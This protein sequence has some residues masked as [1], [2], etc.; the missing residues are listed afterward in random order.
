MNPIHVKL[1]APNPSL[2]SSFACEHPPIEVAWAQDQLSWSQMSES[3]LVFA[4]GGEFILCRDKCHALP[5]AS[6]LNAIVASAE[7]QR[8]PQWLSRSRLVAMALALPTPPGPISSHPRDLRFQHGQRRRREMRQR[9]RRLP[10]FAKDGEISLHLLSTGNLCST[11]LGGQVFSRLGS[12]S[13]IPPHAGLLDSPALVHR[14]SALTGPEDKTGRKARHR[15]YA[16]GTARG[17]EN[18]RASQR[19]A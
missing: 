17:K 5:D 7:A 4:L 15:V 18:L 13:C 19:L 10:V 14:T 1:N 2:L 8:L 9:K 11:R 3:Q 16:E 12:T 6:G